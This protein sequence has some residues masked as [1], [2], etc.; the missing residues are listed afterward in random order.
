MTIVSSK[1]FITN[2]KKYFDLAVSEQVFIKRG[3]NT[4]NL[5]CTNVDDITIDRMVLHEP[6]A[7]FFRSISMNE[8][9]KRALAATERID[10]MYAKK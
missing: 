10:K 3:R 9:K 2:Q 1:E 7:D 4:F 8:F 5:M 6:D